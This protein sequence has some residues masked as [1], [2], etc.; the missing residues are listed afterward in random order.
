MDSRQL[1][2]LRRPPQSQLVQEHRQPSPP[3][4]PSAAWG[5]PDTRNSPQEEQQTQ[6]WV[7]EPPERRRSGR[8]WSFSIDERRR[9]AM[10]GARER[11]DADG[12]PSQSRDITQIVAELVSEDVDKDVLLPHLPRSAA[13]STSSTT[14]HRFLAR[15]APLWQN[16]TFETQT[17]R[18]P[19]S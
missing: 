1:S 4:S 14:F 10:L 15:G 17:S 5:Q 19:P 12:T 8:H 11:Q 9:L 16:S 7:C 13:T 2:P 3:S 18:S 6:D